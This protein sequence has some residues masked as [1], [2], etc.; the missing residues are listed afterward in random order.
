MFLN[1]LR[2]ESSQ[3]VGE[4]GENGLSVRMIKDHFLDL[5]QHFFA[6]LSSFFAAAFAGS[7][8]LAKFATS[9]RPYRRER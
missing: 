4:E 3:T 5:Q 8:A 7:C 2:D 9:L 6:G 1:D